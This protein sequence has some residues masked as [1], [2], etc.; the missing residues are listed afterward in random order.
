MKT[1]KKPYKHDVLP[2]CKPTEVD[3]GCW[4]TTDGTPRGPYWRVTW[5]AA[6]HELYAVRRVGRNEER[7]I[8]GHFVEKQQAEEAMEGWANPNSPI[9]QNLAAL[10]QHLGVDGC[11]S[12]LMEASVKLYANPTSRSKEKQ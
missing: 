12:R 7:V 9:Y 11:N 5:N 10:K 3:F 1:P 6:L 2:N 4:W 8:L